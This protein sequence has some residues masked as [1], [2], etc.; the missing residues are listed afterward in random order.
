MSLLEILVQVYLNFSL[1]PS[2]KCNIAIGDDCM[3]LEK[4]GS[5]SELLD[6]LE[7]ISNNIKELYSNSHS[8]KEPN[9]FLKYGM[10]FQNTSRKAST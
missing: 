4:V 6:S 8:Y 1:A 9:S 3:V 5:G 2:S 7:G 10:A